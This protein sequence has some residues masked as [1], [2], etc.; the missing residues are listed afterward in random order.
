M[1]DRGED[2]GPQWV[3]QDTAKGGMEFDIMEHLT[4]WGPYRYNVAMH[5]D[6]YK[7][8]HKSIGS[9]SIYAKPDKDGFITAGVLWLPGK[10]VYYAQGKEVGHWE[11]QRVCDQPMDLMFDLVTGGWDNDPL[12][13]EQL[14]ADFVIDYVRAWQRKDLATDA[15]GFKQP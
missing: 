1:P 13:D 8:D 7:K 10:L 14:P 15:D 12:D 2:K 9:S 4:R 11:N 6:G 5:W 3:R